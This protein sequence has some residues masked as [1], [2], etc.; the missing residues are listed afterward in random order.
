[1]EIRPMSTMKL[2]AAVVAASVASVLAALAPGAANAQ[3]VTD[4]AMLSER[5]AEYQAVWNTRDETALAA[6]FA[7]DADLVMG[8]Q[9]AARGRAAIEA[10]WRRYFSRQ[11]P[12]RRGTFAVVSAR[13]LTPDVALVNVTSTTHGADVAEDLPVR[14]AR[15]TWVLR[16]ADGEWRIEAM[17][18]LPT[19][20][21]TVELIPSMA[22]AE[23]MR[24]DIRVFVDAYEDAFDLH[25][26]DSLSAFYR[27]DADIIVRDGPFIHGGQAIR[28]WWRTYFSRARP[29]RVLLIIE[30]IRMVADDVALLNVIGTGQPLEAEGRL[31]PTRAARATWVIRRENGEWRIAALRMLPG[32]DDRLVRQIGR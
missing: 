19:E 21:D 5:V 2:P 9:R 20:A 11:E 15:G 32:E 29:Y 28:D 17:R 4:S 25:D 14:R 6:F 13:R 22:L 30:D 12:E 31:V 16:R 23:S 7:E 18:G 8:N 3:A 27:D 1:M 10:F 24:P 26:A